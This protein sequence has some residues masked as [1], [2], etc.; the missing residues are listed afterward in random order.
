ML[1]TDIRHDA[2]QTYIVSLSKADW[3]DIEAHFT[4]LH[5]QLAQL[6]EAERIY[7]QD[8]RFRRSMDMR[9]VGQEYFI[10]VPVVGEGGAK[11]QKSE[12]LKKLFDQ[13]Y[14]AQYGHKNLAEQ[15]EIVNLRM[16][17]RGLLAS[18]EQ[19]VSAKKDTE[20][21]EGRARKLES[22][23][24]RPTIFNG[25][26]VDTAFIERACLLPRMNLL[27]PIVIAEASCTTIVPP[28]YR[29]KVDEHGNLVIRRKEEG[30]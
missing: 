8:M 15:V 12:A 10:N 30:K 9:Y 3:T 22:A 18:K 1:K 27:G 11:V 14:E 26:P 16:E 6:L 23:P 4:G 25:Q 7:P 24:T 21:G 19:G 17:A 28:G 20:G 2:S 5:N 29:L 13:L